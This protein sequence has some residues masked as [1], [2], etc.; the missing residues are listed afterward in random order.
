M[1]FEEALGC[2]VARNNQTEVLCTGPVPVLAVQ[3]NNGQ[4][5]Q[6]SYITNTERAYLANQP[7]DFR[8]KA[9]SD[10]VGLRD[11]ESEQ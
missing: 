2:D 5:L 3:H 6:Y 7:T 1:A 4:S 10:L 8:L 11:Q 9:L